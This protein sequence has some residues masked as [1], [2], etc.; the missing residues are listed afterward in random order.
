VIHA[1]SPPDTVRPTPAYGPAHG[2]LVPMA[3]PTVEPEIAILTGASVMA[4]RL[5]STSSD[6]RTRLLD[7]VDG[8]EGALETFDVAPLASAGFACTCWYLRGAEAEARAVA[9]LSARFGYPVHTSTTAIRRFA[10]ALGAT[11][12]AL[13]APYPAWLAEEALRYFASVGLTITAREGL[14]VDLI[15]T[16]GIY[17]LRPADVDGILARIDTSGADAVLLGG[18]GMPSLDVIAASTRA[19]PL[20]SSNMALASAMSET[21]PAAMLAPGAPWRARLASW[22]RP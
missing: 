13:V 15:D 3:N 2:V 22:R 20:F 4:A 6:S 16:R 10:A 18:T 11:R 1:A 14:P 19:I 21:D 5:A 8:V 12:L 7:Y 9:R 17:R